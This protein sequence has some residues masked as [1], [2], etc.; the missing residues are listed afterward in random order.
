[1]RLLSLAL[2]NLSPIG[3]LRCLLPSRRRDLFGKMLFLRRKL[4]PKW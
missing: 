2:L 1:M 3:K 4:T